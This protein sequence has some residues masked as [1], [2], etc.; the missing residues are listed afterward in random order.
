MRTA[1]SRRGAM[2][3]LLLTPMCTLQAAQ[4]ATLPTP[5]SLQQ[6][7]QIASGK[8]R[9]LVVMVSVAGCGFCTLVRENY[10]APL[11]RRGEID[12]AQLDMRSTASVVDPLGNHTTHEQLI[13]TWGI[14]LAPTLLFLGRRGVEIA[15]RLKG[16]PSAD[17]YGAQLEERLAAAGQAFQG[18]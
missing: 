18:G 5:H 13:R 17:Y 12:V 6:A 3:S 9:P 8:Q 16:M 11:H 10:L 1:L 14:R 4:P 15:E 2:L 7:L